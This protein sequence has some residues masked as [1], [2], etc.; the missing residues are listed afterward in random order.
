MDR[1]RALGVAS[2]RLA[3]GLRARADAAARAWQGVGAPPR[4]AFS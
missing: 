3:G 1:R 4:R 2:G